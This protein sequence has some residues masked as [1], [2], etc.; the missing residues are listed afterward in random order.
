MC[1][2]NCDIP[3]PYWAI[4][5]LIWALNLKGGFLLSHIIL[6]YHRRKRA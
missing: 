5:K 3:E 4:S 2:A 6:Q 1:C